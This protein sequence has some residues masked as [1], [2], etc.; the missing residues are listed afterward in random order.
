MQSRA[1]FTAKAAVKAGWLG[2][3]RA[4]SRAHPSTGS[5]RVHDRADP[6]MTS[7]KCGPTPRESPSRKWSKPAGDGASSRREVLSPWHARAPNVG[8]VSKAGSTERKTLSEAGKEQPS[9]KVTLHQLEESGNRMRSN[10]DSPPSDQVTATPP[11]PV[12]P[13]LTSATADVPPP[14]QRVTSSA[15]SNTSNAGRTVN[16]HWVSTTQ[17]AAA[18]WTAAV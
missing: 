4:V 11:S 2:T 17:A 18:P 3:R 9:S 16:V 13:P 10:R 12:S 14:G 1:G 15:V 7:V 5:M 8:S 6:A